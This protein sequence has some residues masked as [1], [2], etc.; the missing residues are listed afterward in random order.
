MEKLSVLRDCVASCR[1][2][3]VRGLLAGGSVIVFTLSPEVTAEAQAS[4]TR[5]AIRIANDYGPT[6]LMGGAD[7][8]I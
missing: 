6:T 1:R 2:W 5:S 4:E 7:R 8:R 3:L